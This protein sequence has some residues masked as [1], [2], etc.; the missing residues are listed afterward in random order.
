MEKSKK[1]KFHRIFFLS[2]RLDKNIETNFLKDNPNNVGGIMYKKGKNNCIGE[3]FF[4][5]KNYADACM[6]S[7]CLSCI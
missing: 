7:E 3:I 1:K 6:E 4:V 5:Q 2:C